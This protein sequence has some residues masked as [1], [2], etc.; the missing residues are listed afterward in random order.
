MRLIHQT[1]IVHPNAQIGERVEIG[2]YCVIG[3]EVTIGDGT[4]LYNHVTVGGPTVIGSDCEFFPFSVMGAAP[5]DLKFG[6]EHATLAIG[7]RN[8]IRE[9]VTIHRGTANGGGKT[10]IGN[11]NLFMV[12][13]HVAHD[14]VVGSHCVIANQVMIGGHA[15]L[16]DFVAIGG[17]AG[18]HH[19]STLGKLSFIGG[20]VRIKKDVPPF[21]KIEGEPAEVRGL[22]TIA[23]NRGH[24][25]DT[26][27]NALRSVYKQLFHH[28]CNGNGAG[29]TK[30]SQQAK[31]MS[32]AIEDILTEYKQIAPIRYLCEF[33]QRSNNGVYGRSHERARRDDKNS[34]TVEVRRANRDAA[35]SSVAPAQ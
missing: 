35:R 1:A 21:M 20:M 28:R 34:V 22:N 8:T 25:D 14:C 19:F 29:Q 6:G 16:E 30:G 7:D 24:F 13:A 2:P 9:H 32:L 4:V 5:Q 12:S 26:E 15:V 33:M 10:I 3:P 17:G 11:D 27:I 18:I 31:P 23:L